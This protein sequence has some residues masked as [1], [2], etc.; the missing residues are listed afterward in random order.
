[1]T[2]FLEYSDNEHRYFANGVEMPS[3]TQILDACGLISPFCKDE[4]ARY[5]GSRVHEICASDD[6]RLLDLRK[7]SVDVRGYLRAWRLYRHES[8]FVPRLI[9]TRIDCQQFGYAGRL[10]RFGEL[11]TQDPLVFRKVILDIKTSKSGAIADY[12]RLQLSA[13]AFALDPKKWCDYLRVVVSLMPNGKYRS[14]PYPL[15]D[16]LRDLSEWIELVKKHKE[17]IIK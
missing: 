16:N 6:F 8:G 15:T 10:D 4:E 12:P 1:M 14:K 3:V 13:Y 7:V 11:P 17:Q 2:E 5:R 9:E